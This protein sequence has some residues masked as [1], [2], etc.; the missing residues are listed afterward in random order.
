MALPTYMWRQFNCFVYRKHY[1]SSV[2]SPVTCFRQH[3]CTVSACKHACTLAAS[4][5]IKTSS[6]AT[7]NFLTSKDSS[8]TEEY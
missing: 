3:H 2:S 7:N 1:T 5:D 8:P 4:A 6:P